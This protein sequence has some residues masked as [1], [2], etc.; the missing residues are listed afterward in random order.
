MYDSFNINLSII[1]NKQSN[2]SATYWPNVDCMSRARIFLNIN[3]VN[4]MHTYPIFWNGGRWKRAQTQRN[5]GFPASRRFRTTQKRK[6]RRKRVKREENATAQPFVFIFGPHSQRSK[7]WT[8]PFPKLR[9]DMHKVFH[10]SPL[11]LVA[12][13]QTYS[14]A[15]YKVKYMEIR[16][17]N[18]N[19][20]N[21]LHPI[22]SPDTP[23]LAFLTFLISN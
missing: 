18:S 20:Y 3:L 11:F 5:A 2:S 22:I 17:I 19:N 6:E 21:K 10:F 4:L 1:W 12:G 9:V 23:A 16:R 7:T 8:G 14:P 15:K 13:I